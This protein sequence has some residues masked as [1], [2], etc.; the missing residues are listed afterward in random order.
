MSMGLRYEGGFRSLA[1][2]LY[3]VKIYQQGYVGAVTEVAFCDDPLM[4]EWPEVDKMEPVMSSNATLRLYSD[5]DRQFVDLY[6][7]EA[8]SVRMDVFRNG[9]PYWSGT[10]DPELYEEPFAYKSDYAVEITFA[11]FAIL[12][13][14]PWERR[15]FM[16]LRE[17]INETI[18]R[19][20]ITG[21]TTVEH[22]S[23]KMS[24]T[25]NEKILDALTVNAA[26]FFD[27]DGDPMSMR[28]ALDETLR[29]F[30]LRLTQ[31]SGRLYLYDLNA[32]YETITPTPIRWELDDSILGVDKV[33]NN[34]TVTF[35]PY[36]KDKLLNGDVDPVRVGGGTTVTTQVYATAPADEVGFKI[37]LSDKGE[38][39]EVTPPAKYFKISPVYSGQMEGGVAW[40]VKTFT[41][42]VV[43]YRSY[44][45]EPTYNIGNELMSVKDTAYISA[46]GAD[47]RDYRLKVNLSLLFD[48]R[49]NPFEEPQEQNEEGDYERLRNWCNFAYVPMMLTL[50][51][52]DGKALCHWENR[53]VKESNSFVHNDT[54]CQWVA[55]EGKWGDAWLCWY[56]GDR[57]SETGLGGWQTNKQIIGYYRGERLPLLYDKM[58]A[59]EYVTMPAMAGYLE[60][61]IGTGVLCYDY[62]DKTEW[63]LRTDIYDKTRW[64]LYKKP[65]VTLVKSNG[66]SIEARDL[67][68]K[69]WINKKAKE[70]MSIETVIGTMRDPS[71]VAQGQLYK[72]GELTAV[73]SLYRGGNMDLVERLLIGTVYSNYATR[74]TTLSG[75]VAILTDFGIYTDSN[76]PGI[77]TLLSEEQNLRAD[78]SSILM[79][80]F[81]KDNYKGVEFDET[82]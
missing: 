72:S 45:N 34:V 11:D 46:I 60:L 58:D 74:H 65:E 76:E 18:A 75:T 36:E 63:K 15:G 81:D 20:G 53:G 73:K 52:R 66:K 12:D 37:T 17:I 26:N 56:Q 62:G 57:K 25:G 2:T 42:S 13:R 68:H 6:T 27:E 55:G 70:G 82:V 71:P 47:R 1:Q 54:N 41:G 61:K 5:N 10:L 3:E 48:V 22:I 28:E 21:R 35:S 79:A 14:I 64:V 43:A 24:E 9:S 29:P 30:A 51:D 31:K 80:Q 39:V 38:G 44:L 4:I 19:S 59:A 32:I 50:R 33:Y 8:G 69:A 40:S 49:Y 23:T 78:E 16:T 77:Y 67:E 7:I